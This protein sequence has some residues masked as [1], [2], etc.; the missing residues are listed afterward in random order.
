MGI[1][2]EELDN[3][4]NELHLTDIFPSKKINA[5]SR[6]A[7]KCKFSPNT[8]IIATSSADKTCKLWRTSDF[9][10][11][12]TLQDETQNWV[13]DLC[14]SNDS[15]YLFSASSDNTARSWELPGET[16]NYTHK[17]LTKYQ[18]NGHQMAVT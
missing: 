7:L 5:H 18:N 11:I 4:H 6:Y 16:N 2:S 13:W 9:S 15:K 14:F 17:L 12:A 10:L 1:L 3:K 8:L